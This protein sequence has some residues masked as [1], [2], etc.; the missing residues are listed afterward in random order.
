MNDFYK[1]IKEIQK[2]IAESAKYSKSC[3]YS[4]TGGLIW[5]ESDEDFYKRMSEDK[6]GYLIYLSKKRQKILDEMQIEVDGLSKL[7]NDFESKMK[8]KE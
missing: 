8:E 6:E 1:E 7:I 4:G 3:C 2:E 5:E